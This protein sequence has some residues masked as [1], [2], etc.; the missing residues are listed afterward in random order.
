MPSRSRLALQLDDEKII[1]QIHGTVH[2]LFPIVYLRDLGINVS[3]EQQAQAPRVLLA[4][5]PKKS[6]TSGMVYPS[7]VPRNALPA[8][9]AL[10]VGRSEVL[11]WPF[12]ST[13][14]SFPQ[15]VACQVQSFVSV[16]EESEQESRKTVVC[17]LW[18][19]PQH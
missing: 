14:R 18:C 15:T 17:F 4:L 8:I 9:R 3:I 5:T 7:V 12:R 10:F 2:E 1:P 16:C 6:G 11:Q 13:W 19:Y